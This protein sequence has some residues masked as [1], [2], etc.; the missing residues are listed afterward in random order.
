[1]STARGPSRMDLIVSQ[2]WLTTPRCRGV[3]STRT[4]DERLRQFEGPYLSLRVRRTLTY[5]RSDDSV[6]NVVKSQIE[7]KRQIPFYLLLVS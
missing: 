7:K 5:I 4:L 6:V 1:M 2:S 3:C